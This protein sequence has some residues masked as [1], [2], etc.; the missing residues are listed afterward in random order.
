[1]RAIVVWFLMCGVVLADDDK[2]AAFAFLKKNA[3]G[4]LSEILL[5]ENEDPEGYRV[6]VEEAAEAA[7]EHGRL[8][9]LGERAAAAAY[10]RMYRIDFDAVA[11]A[12]EIVMSG[13]N[14]E[15]ERMKEELRRLVDASFEQWLIVE[16]ARVERLEREV[17]ALREDFEAVKANR[18]EVVAEDC[19]ALLE[20]TRAFR[21]GG[22]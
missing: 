12:D 1:M 13:D 22:E 21:R 6:S 16:K 2:D 3:P 14:A 5:L 8:V 20:E 15:R 9:E 4:V 18:A 17:A 10:L 7:R 19:E 11:V